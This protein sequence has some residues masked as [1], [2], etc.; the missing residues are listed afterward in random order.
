MVGS[1]TVP[2]SVV[3]GMARAALTRFKASELYERKIVTCAD[4]L[5]AR[6]KHTSIR[7]ILLR[8]DATL[9]SPADKVVTA[10]RKSSV[11]AFNPFIISGFSPTENQWSDAIAELLDP[12][13]AH[14]FGTAPLFALLDALEEEANCRN[15]N[16]ELTAIRRAIECSF[17]TAIRVRRECHRQGLGKPDIV[18]VRDGREG[19]LILIENKMWGGLETHNKNGYQSIRYVK[20]I[21]T[22]CAEAGIPVGRALGVYLTPENKS[23]FSPKFLPLSC[24][25][26][27]RS[28]MQA[29]AA[30]G[31][32]DSIGDVTKVY[33]T[34]YAW[35]NGGF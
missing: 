5:L 20:W 16:A 4:D 24:S 30:S 34:T 19:F 29:I 6:F 28:I 21:E 25:K 9:I 14:G 8:E 27:S 31:R 10:F 12:T 23:P 13:S 7:D 22:H 35:L 15:L 2:D 33:L 3:L 11:R 26:L 32:A 18:I 1:A 17:P